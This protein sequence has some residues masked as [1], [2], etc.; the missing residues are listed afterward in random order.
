MKIISADERLAERRGAKCLIVGPPGVGKTTLLRTLD[1]ART[2]FLDVEA[3]GSVRSAGAD[4][5]D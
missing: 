2:L 5:P 1:P 4:A 3:G